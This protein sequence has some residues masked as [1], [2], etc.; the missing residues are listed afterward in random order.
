LDN[1]GVDEN[2]D[3][4]MVTDTGNNV[5]LGLQNLDFTEQSFFK[6]RSPNGQKTHETMLWPRSK[7]KS[8]PH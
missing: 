5:T 1:G 6:G 8:K 3:N 4:N 7:C 2:D